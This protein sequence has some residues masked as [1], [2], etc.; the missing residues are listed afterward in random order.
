MKGKGEFL[1]IICKDL[2]KLSGRTIRG[3]NRKPPAAYKIYE[4]L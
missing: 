4:D 1:L 2:S 3:S